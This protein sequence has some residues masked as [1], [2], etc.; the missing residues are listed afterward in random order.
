MW[1]GWSWLLI[2]VLVFAGLP[3]RPQTPEPADPAPDASVRLWLV[4]TESQ[5][6][7]HIELTVKHKPEYRAEQTIV[8]DCLLH[9]NATRGDH[10][11]AFDIL[12]RQGEPVYQGRI[13]LDVRPGENPCRFTWDAAPAPDGIYTARIALHRDWGVTSARQDIAITKLTSANV[14]A[15]VDAADAA[16]RGVREALDASGQAQTLSYPAVRAAVATDA[17]TLARS[18]FRKGDWR[19]ADDLARYV[20]RAVDSVRAQITFAALTPELTGDLPRPDLSVVTARDGAFYADDCPLFLVGAHGVDPASSSALAKLRQYGLNLAVTEVSPRIT[21]PDTGKDGDIAS[22]LDP[23]FRNARRHNIAVACEF[24]PEDLDE[25]IL[26]RWPAI[27]QS[28]SS[29]GI[30]LN[31][32]RARE[33][34]R[35]HIRILLTYLAQQKMVAGVCLA[36]RPAFM[37]DSEDVRRQFIQAVTE[38]Y[39]ERQAVNRAWRTRLRNLNEIEILWDYRRASYQYEW[40]SFHQRLGAQYLGWLRST[41]GQTAPRVPAYIKLADNAFQEGESRLGIDRESLAGLMDF[42]GCAVACAQDDPGYALGFPQ[43]S[44]HYALLRS[45][46]P[47]SPV[48]NSEA[49]LLLNRNASCDEA[50]RFVHAAVWQG[51]VAGMNAIAVPWSAPTRPNDPFRRVSLRETPEAADALAVAALD[52]NRL[53]DVVLAFQQ[54]PAEVAVVWSAPS[55]IYE[56]GDPFLASAW[57]AYEGCSLFGHKVRFMS[58]NQIVAGGLQGVRALVLPQAMSLSEPAFQAIDAYVTGGGAL[59]RGARPAPYDDRGSSRHDVIPFTAQTILITGPDSPTAYLHAM[60]AVHSRGVLESIPRPVNEFGYPIEGVLTRYVRVG[61]AEFLFAVNIRKTPVVVPLFGG[62]RTGR[63]V[64]QGRAVAFPETL[65]PLEVM[66]ARLDP[67]PDVVAEVLS[68]A[69]PA[70]IPQA[71]VEPIPEPEPPPQPPAPTARTLHHRP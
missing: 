32:P 9:A 48:L 2:A 7:R 34:V 38:Q 8:F 57:R 43:V 66:L 51:A 50:F 35:N 62:P 18:S 39:Q 36:D 58:E 26:K 71:A 70:G 47:Q 61:D 55:K 19:R 52:L 16:V 3:A 59:I 44:A 40:Q 4:P 22:V 20:I 24:S 17:V 63:D 53:V 12:D 56:N 13:P 67:L 65:A 6:D 30:D 68:S 49:T 1:R 54:A 29:G 46:A 31:H 25:W 28:L 15:A 64:I 5:T 21:L 42:T 45:F 14:Q 10:I 37:F 41:A 11:V 33:A 69:E 23:L 60:D 27:T